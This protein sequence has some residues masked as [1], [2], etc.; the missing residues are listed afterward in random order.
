MNRVRALIYSD[1]EPY[2]EHQAHKGLFFPYFYALIFVMRRLVKKIL[3][4]HKE[5]NFR[6]HILRATGV[7]A[8]L[9]FVLGTLFV[10]Q[11]YR[12]VLKTNNFLAS[13][14]P[15]VL[16]DLANSDR[17]SYELSALTINP[18]LSEAARLK[19]ADMALHGYFAHESPTGVTP[20]HWF[21]KAG[22]PFLYAGENL[23][24]DFDDSAAVNDAWMNSPGHRA[25]ILSGH[26]NEIGIATAEGIH[27]GRRTVFVVQMF[28]S[29]LPVQ[30]ASAVL[31][32]PSEFSPPAEE[33]T[34]S[35][36]SIVSIEAEVPVVAIQE[37]ETDAQS[38]VAVKNANAID[39]SPETIAAVGASSL[40]QYSSFIDRFVASPSKLLALVYAIIGLILL[41][42]LCGVLFVR[43]DHRAHHVASV[44][45]MILILVSAYYVYRASDSSVTVLSA[46]VSNV[47]WK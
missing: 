17:A 11:T 23:A 19:A 5:N 29:Q 45:V 18:L 12:I 43:H 9:V 3:I 42:V 38:F 41:I 47:L 30:S 24:I 35:E 22:Y 2:F 34:E 15:S 10:S 31:P 21:T 37:S 6:P 8:L 27:N 44:C 7:L 40:T 28:G 14:L 13:V 26:F 20:W 16:V 4:P 32:V 36:V 1:L 33:V 46:E 39:V 25:N